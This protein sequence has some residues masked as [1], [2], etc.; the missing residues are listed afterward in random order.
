MGDSERLE[1]LSTLCL[2]LSGEETGEGRRRAAVAIAEAIA[3][4][5]AEAPWVEAQLAGF[6]ADASAPTAREG[7]LLAVQA[8]SQ[9]AR[10][11][12]EPFLAALLPATL[13]AH[14]DAAPAV[15]HAAV[16]AGQALV[17]AL[18][19]HALRLALP[20]VLEGMDSREWRIKVRR[21]GVDVGS[22]HTLCA[23]AARLALPHVLEGMD[24]REW[25]IK[26]WDTHRQ[27]QAASKHALLAACACIANPDIEP[28][29]D[30]LVSV[31][32]HPEETLATLDALMATT[33]VTRVDGATLSVIAPL[34]GKCLRERAAAMR[35]K[36][37][38]VISNM[39][40]LVMDPVDVAPF[41]PL[42]L[43]ALQKVVA[44]TS[45]PEVTAVAQEALDTLVRALGGGAAA[46]KA[47]GGAAPGPSPE[48]V[49]AM[50]AEM[51]GHLRRAVMAH[52]APAAA[53]ATAVLS[54]DGE[55]DEEGS[56]EG[57][58]GV[59]AAK[60]PMTDAALGYVA[61]LCTSLVLYGRGEQVRLRNRVR[62]TAQGALAAD[63]G[64]GDAADLCNIEFSLAYGGK[65]LL[66]NTRLR[67]R[68]GHRYGLI[69][70][71]GAGKTTLM[72]NIANGNIDGLP[73]DLRTVYVEHDIVG[74]DADTPVAEFVASVLPAS[75]DAD[76]TARRAR[77][78]ATLSGVGFTDAMLAAPVSSL[79]GGWKMKLAL[80]RAMLMNANVLLL[81][82][83]TNH[84]DTTAVAWLTRYLASLS[85]VTVLVVSHDTAF[86][87]DVVTDILHYE[88]Q[89]LVPY[90]GNL[91]HFVRL[92]PE[93]KSYYELDAAT[94]RF[95]F[96][97]PGPLDGINST[98]KSILT[99]NNATYT[100][101]GADKPTL[102]EASLKL[103]LASRVAVTGV[104]GA[105]KTT[106]IRLVVRESEP[107]SGE[108]W[109]H[110]NLRIA[111]VAQHSFH[112]VEQHL[113]KSPVQY[114]QWRYG[115]GDGTDREAS[116]NNMAMKL[117]AEE[118]E[119]LAKVGAVERILGRRKTGRTLEY[120]CSF[121]GMGD[122]YNRYITLEKL[123]DMGCQKLVQQAD[124]RVAAQAAG[125][126][127]RP[128]TTR[129]IQ[130]HLDDFALAP[131][132]SVHGKIGGL[133]GGQKVKLV[134]AAAM[135][136]RPHLL[137]LDEPTNYLDREALGAL[138]IG[139]KEFGGGVIM[140]SHNQEF[141]SAICTETWTL[142]AGRLYT[143]GEVRETALRFARKKDAL[144]DEPEEEAASAG[145]TNKTVSYDN[146]INPKSLK[147]LSKKEVRKLAK[148]AEK[149]EIPLPEYV[150]K[151]TRA[152]PEWKWLSA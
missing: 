98:T 50:R 125:L 78:V 142:E 14:A 2:M 116:A 107:D 134:L 18:S 30:R 80:A 9:L 25:R 17:R 135:W 74:S 112:H 81:D 4:S 67:L 47:R 85:D 72:R 20:S 123:A 28:L 138:T 71:N 68:A 23:R 106:L 35:R 52:M 5:S 16:D 22:L 51:L 58:G 93:A 55:D 148:L 129:E 37:A 27:V 147:A 110:H 15:R 8:Q 104:N 11:A 56:E 111:Y 145:C 150:S 105:G 24:S 136:N 64:D 132:F 88:S 144:G 73:D 69:G 3:A 108:I 10:H 44:E 26:V 122:E 149:A 40:K 128:T 126:D 101:P 120:E 84:L 33:F 151:I 43:P 77:I 41:V 6:L 60:S 99:M 66:H 95:K 152:S 79:S 141:L 48:E 21:Y 121:V 34:L 82:E 119:R 133:S 36:A 75:D 39:C 63:D 49:T 124:A 42:L 12:A 76:A 87:D 53:V 139:I 61:A 19:P 127:V 137:V 117:T 46:A 70:A 45:D 59:V 91:T 109:A 130:A 1:R 90:H 100:Y 140:I 54:E 86:L 7:A 114:M 32:A 57:E 96:P 65:I 89:K 143:K 83:P 113:S 38:R 146:L 92:R 103:C 62:L 118:E 94:L 31:I 102:A 29:V 97:D 13:A 131:E 115:A